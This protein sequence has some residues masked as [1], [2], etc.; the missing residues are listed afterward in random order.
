MEGSGDRVLEGTSGCCDQKEIGSGE[1]KMGQETAG[2]GSADP[3]GLLEGQEV[4]RLRLG[5]RWPLTPG[6][7]RRRGV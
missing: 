6:W 2:E 3:A 5:D 4:E 7:K 1:G